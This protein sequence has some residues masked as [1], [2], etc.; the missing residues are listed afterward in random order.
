MIAGYSTQ[1][2]ASLMFNSLPEIVHSRC[3]GLKI[4]I[5]LKILHATIPVEWIPVPTM[6][7]P[8]APGDSPL[9]SNR[10]SN[11]EPAAPESRSV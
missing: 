2:N 1:E 8:T 6:V 4:N 5:Q 3:D 7:P 10:L 9:P 11:T